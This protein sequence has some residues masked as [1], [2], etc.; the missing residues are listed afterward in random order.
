MSRCPH[1]RDRTASLSLREGDDGTVLLHCHAGCSSA[2]VVR[3]AGLAWADLF[4]SGSRERRRTRA[5]IPGIPIAPHG[6]PAFECFGDEVVA[7]DLGEIARLAYVQGRHDAKFVRALE[8]VAA[9]VGVG[10]QALAK[11]A[12]AAIETEREESP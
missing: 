12:R 11:A 4:P 10:R 3:S 5:W 1:H 2:D 9:G 7:A 6:G 8:T